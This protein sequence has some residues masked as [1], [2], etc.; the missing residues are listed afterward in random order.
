MRKAIPR[1]QTSRP[2][3]FLFN[4]NVDFYQ[5]PN[6]YQPQLMVNHPALAPPPFSPYAFFPPSHYLSKP[7]PLM[8]TPNSCSQPGSILPPPTFLLP[9][10]IATNTLF[11]NQTFP[12]P[13]PSTSSTARTN[14]TTNNNNNTNSNAQNQNDNKTR[15][16]N[17]LQSPTNDVS[18]NPQV[19]TNNPDLVNY[20][21]PMKSKPR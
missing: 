2:N 7:M 13:P 5:P 18:A 4:T 10:E 1:D 16:N 11:R 19:T 9:P 14:N 17:D 21:T 8:S 15:L 12:S 20:S 6:R 3:A